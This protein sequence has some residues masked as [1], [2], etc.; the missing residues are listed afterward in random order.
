MYLLSGFQLIAQGMSVEPGTSIKVETGTT[1][2]IS[3]GNLVLLSDATGDASLIDV[4]TVSYSGSGEANVQ[5]YLTND[6]W[7]L[8]S[9]PITTALSGIFTGDFLQI[10][11]ENTNAY[12]DVVSATYQLIPMKGY[13]LW[14]VEA[15]PTTEVFEGITNTGNQS[16]SFTKAGLGYNL[17][18]NP[19][20]S[21]I[22]WDAVIIPANLNGSFQLWDPATGTYKYYI[23]GGGGANTT[24]QY[25]PSGQ[26]FFTWATGGPGTL[27][28]DN[29]ARTHGTQLFYKEEIEQTMLVLKVSGNEITTQ[30][31]I[32][33]NE[34][35]SPQ[36]DR[37][38]DVPKI[39]SDYPNV[40]NLYSFADSQA[41]AINTLPT[42]KDHE[43]V[44]VSFKAGTDGTYSIM[45]SELASIPEEVPVFLE[46]TELNYF[47]DLR[48]GP[49]YV[50]NYTTG[51]N[52]EF[53]VHFKG[54][55]DIESLAEGR[56]LAVNCFLSGNI[57][58]VNFQKAFENI[59]FDATISLQSITGQL[60]LV[61]ETSHVVNEI[62]FDGSQSIY[63]VS[64]R[65][66]DG[67]YSTK[68]FNR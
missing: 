60:L 44:P 8:V 59:Q 19:Y 18:G 65:T 61:K 31:A 27:N 48:A 22:D 52:R 57:L 43:I 47:Q 7:H 26:G 36:I 20:P 58:H 28:L 24:S 25:I 46:D 41:M 54:V 9:S 49:Q 67:N 4:G 38:F 42:I 68:L 64:I 13:S 15:A 14:S 17:I 5:R 21:A 6:T 62:P 55:T 50:F 34:E 1:L 56:Q 45:A 11:S 53:N 66:N 10:H 33:F 30:T 29:S 35:A 3:A 39:I 32:R 63:I 40:P 37:L 12:T 51:A 2:D 23:E 16:F